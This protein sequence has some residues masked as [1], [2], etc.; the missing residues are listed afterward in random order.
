[1][2]HFALVSHCALGDTIPKKA[3]ETEISLSPKKSFHESEWW[4]FLWEQNFQGLYLRYEQI[5]LA[6]C[7][8]SLSLVGVF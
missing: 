1:M 2:T 5:G 6:T 7:K 8:T 3:V 4:C